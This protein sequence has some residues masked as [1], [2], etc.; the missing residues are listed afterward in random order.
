MTRLCSIDRRFLRLVGVVP[1]HRCLLNMSFCAM[2]HRADKESILTVF[3]KLFA[4]FSHST[5]P[6]IQ[7]V[8][9]L[10]ETITQ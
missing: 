4:A 5:N 6:T 9:H 8:P 7:H 3:A 10:P 2:R 1:V